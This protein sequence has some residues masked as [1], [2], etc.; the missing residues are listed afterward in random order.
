MN[1]SCS[2]PFSVIGTMDVPRDRYI[3][4][5]SSLSECINVTPLL[6][7]GCSAYLAI[8]GRGSSSL[9]TSIRSGFSC[10]VDN[11]VQTF[12]MEITGFF[13][14]PSLDR[15]SVDAVC[16]MSHPTK[17]HVM[18]VNEELKFKIAS[19]KL[20]DQ[21]RTLNCG[22]YRRVYAQITVHKVLL[23][24]LDNVV[25][26]WEVPSGTTITTSWIGTE[27]IVIATDAKEVICLQYDEVQNTDCFMELEK[28]LM[29][30][31]VTCV[32]EY[33]QNIMIGTIDRSVIVCSVNRNVLEDRTPILLN[34][35][36]RFIYSFCVLQ[37]PQKHLISSSDDCLI[38]GGDSGMIYYIAL[39]EDTG[40][41]STIYSRQLDKYRLFCSPVT[42]HGIPAIVV[43]SISSYNIIYRSNP[44]EIHPLFFVVKD[45][46]Q[47]KFKRA[48]QRFLGNL[49][50]YH[51]QQMELTVMW[52]GEDLIVVTLGQASD[53][54]SLKSV[55]MISTGHRMISLPQGKVMVISHNFDRN[56]GMHNSW[57]IFALNEFNTLLS[58]S[59]QDLCSER[60]FV[61]ACCVFNRK[62]EEGLVR[63]WVVVGCV[64]EN[65]YSL[66]LFQRDLT[67]RISI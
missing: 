12:K 55:S 64:G 16:I 52:Q 33:K 6:T 35:I 48:S 67:N 57:T 59:L 53:A 8:H 20:I 65:R 60:E 31:E 5:P 40:D 49:F 36:P 58:E 30:S 13:S 56:S 47:D 26:L 4:I 2:I 51:M 54:I 1:C 25:A 23:T 37:E 24:T 42:L 34:S 3:Q 17:S 50:V 28:K 38:I 9:V 41:F 27:Y 19:T 18:F 66:R 21:E 7:T 44:F 62:A 39:N 29:K 61:S 45:S 46:I 11:F 32:L 15:P 63:D 10:S 43:S 22:V 14:L